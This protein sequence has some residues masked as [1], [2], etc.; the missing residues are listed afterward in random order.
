MEG[1]LIQKSITSKA[2]TD[3]KF[4]YQCRSNFSLKTFIRGQKGYAH[5]KTPE[6]HVNLKNNFEVWLR[7]WACVLRWLTAV[8]NCYNCKTVNNCCY[9]K[10]NLL[11]RGHSTLPRSFSRILPPPLT[12]NILFSWEGD[13]PDS[14]PHPTT[15]LL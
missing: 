14:S 5:Y 15:L 4:Y 12:S 8:N 7:D 13:A 9:I 10:K 3:I 6:K 1:P 11:Q 2:P